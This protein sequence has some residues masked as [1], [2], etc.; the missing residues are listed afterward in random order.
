[1]AT[2]A[3]SDADALHCLFVHVLQELSLCDWRATYDT[4]TMQTDQLSL[5]QLIAAPVVFLPHQRGPKPSEEMKCCSLPRV[6][7]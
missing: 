4:F 7:T 5:G 3:E 1:M 2:V 6:A